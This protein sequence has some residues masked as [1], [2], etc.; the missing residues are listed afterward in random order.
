MMKRICLWGWM[1]LVLLLS[2]CSSTKT[3]KKSVSIDGMDETEYV[4]TV[5]TN[6]VS[7]SALTAKMALTLNLDGKGDTKVSGTLRIKKGEVIQM[8]IAPF[9]GIDSIIYYTHHSHIFPTLHLK[10]L[11]YLS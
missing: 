2:S 7:P 10:A 8:S 3:V 6:A 11:D 1:V 4:E 5:L 9:L